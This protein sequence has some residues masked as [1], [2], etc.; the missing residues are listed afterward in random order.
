MV[1]APPNVGREYLRQEEGYRIQFQ[2]FAQR[3]CDWHGQHNNRDVVE[4]RGGNRGQNRKQHKKEEAVA[5]DQLSALDRRPVEGSG[6][7]GD[8]R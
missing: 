6:S 2:S 4:K 8:V 5:P 3:Q 1:A 7:A